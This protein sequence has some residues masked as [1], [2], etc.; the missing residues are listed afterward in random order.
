MAQDTVACL[1]F[2]ALMRARRDTG[3]S[4]PTPCLTSFLMILIISAT[5]PKASLSLRSA[6][7]TPFTSSVTTDVSSTSA[8]PAAQKIRYVLS[9]F[10]RM[11][12][13]HAVFSIENVTVVCFILSTFKKTKKKTL[14]Q[15]K[16]SSQPSYV[17]SIFQMASQKSEVMALEGGK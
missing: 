16:V 6:A 13:N 12:C 4:G 10:E 17:T 7:T 1:T 5:Y 3:H 8:T 14:L 2:S 15:V 11:T 9:E